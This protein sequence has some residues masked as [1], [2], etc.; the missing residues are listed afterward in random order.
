MNRL[1]VMFLLGC[2]AIPANL[3]ADDAVDYFNRGV[4]SL[5]K[6][7][8]DKAIANF[9]EAIRL[10]PNYEPAY[11][12]RGIAWGTKGDCEKAIADFNAAIRLNP[13]NPSVYGHAAS[14][15]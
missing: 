11:A 15:G 4:A 7:K 6:G 10:D 14:P 3:H 13:N 1:F 9:T 8:H 5:R 12:L 2:L